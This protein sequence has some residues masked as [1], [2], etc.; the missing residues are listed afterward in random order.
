MTVYCNIKECVNNE[1]LPDPHQR[2]YGR[3]YT[4]IGDSG[5]YTGKCSLPVFNVKATTVHTFQTKHIIPECANYSESTDSNIEKS[6]FSSCNEKRCLHF[7]EEKGCVATPD[8]YVDWITVVNLGDKTRYPKC[9]SFSN[10]GI[11][12]HIDW[13]KSGIR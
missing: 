8:L 13:S 6:E 3:S 12:G 9:N 11:S 10:R 1:E 2:S 4:P 7:H 5:Q